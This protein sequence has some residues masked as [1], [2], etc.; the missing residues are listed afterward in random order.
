MSMWFPMTVNSYSIC[1]NG[2]TEIPENKTKQ[3]KTKQ[4]KP[5]KTTYILY[6]ETKIT[7]RKRKNVENEY[8]DGQMAITLCYYYY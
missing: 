5:K 8:G 1:D 2:H 3:N 6:K 4:T 7:L